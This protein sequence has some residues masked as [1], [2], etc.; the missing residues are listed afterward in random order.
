MALDLS[1]S[2]NLE[3]LAIQPTYLY[4][5]VS[6]QLCCNTLC[7]HPCLAVNWLLFKSHRQFIPISN[8]LCLESTF[9][10]SLPAALSAHFTHTS[11]SFSCSSLPPCVIPSVFHSRLK[12]T[13]FTYSF[14]IDCWCHTNRSEFRE[15]LF[16]WFLMLNSFLVTLIFSFVL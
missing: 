16:F 15:S 5:F 9:R 14:V 13:C 8:T 1:N 10:F 6:L 2:S 4:N 11:Q 3:Q 7:C 12:L